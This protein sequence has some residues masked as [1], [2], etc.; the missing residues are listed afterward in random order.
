MRENIVKLY[1][2]NLQGLKKLVADIPCD[3]C[4]EEPLGIKPPAW[5]MGHL[6]VA[7]GF[8]GQLFGGKANVP[9]AW[10]ET[11]FGYTAG[12]PR[13]AYPKKAELI[14]ALERAHAALAE[15]FLRA[16]EA[17]LA[18]VPDDE[19]AA[20]FFGTNGNAAFYIMTHNESYHI[21]QVSAWRRAAGLAPVDPLA[22]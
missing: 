4:G 18:A 7:S 10:M 5:Q 21:G 14:D 9:G 17:H 11:C 8:V 22:T 3:R 15:G 12:R 2:S 6:A 16:S 19:M 13:A 20:R 1:A